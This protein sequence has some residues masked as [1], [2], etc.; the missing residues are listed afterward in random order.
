VT[1]ECSKVRSKPAR[2]QVARGAS[3]TGRGGSWQGTS[4]TLALVV[5]T[6]QQATRC[7]VVCRQLVSGSQHG[8]RG[9]AK[10]AT[11]ASVPAR[12]GW[13]ENLPRL[14]SKRCSGAPR[15]QP[16][17]PVRWRLGS[18]ATETWVE[19]LLRR[20]TRF[21]DPTHAPRQAPTFAASTDM[22]NCVNGE[23]LPLGVARGHPSLWTAGVTAGDIR[24]RGSA[25][26]DSHPRLFVQS[27]TTAEEMTARTG[28]PCSV[29]ARA[30]CEFTA[31]CPRAARPRKRSR[32]R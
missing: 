15:E 8:L 13:E 9:D 25:S 10:E 24:F 16:P 22:D 17:Y 7:R 18:E 26:A 3:I 23:Y 32:L 19:A 1:A 5:T 28:C 30:H 4:T 12:A 11:P 6:G 2:A 21:S 29:A 20:A 31:A 27:G 14:T